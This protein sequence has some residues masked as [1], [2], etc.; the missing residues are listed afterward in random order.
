M[1]CLEFNSP[2][3]PSLTVPCCANESWGRCLRFAMCWLPLLPADTTATGGWGLWTAMGKLASSNDKV[4]YGLSSGVLIALQKS[5]EF[6]Y[7]LQSVF[8]NKDISAAAI[9][10]APGK[11]IV[12]GLLS[13]LFNIMATVIYSKAIKVGPTGEVSAIGAAYPA[14]AMVLSRI[15]MSEA[16]DRNSAIGMLFFLAAGVM[17]ALLKPV[18]AAVAN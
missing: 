2:R 13:G 1:A 11:G 14:D 7:V 10:A 16:I 4:G 15:L 6:V 8:T 9:R 17:F 5:V 18:P 12:A 3:R